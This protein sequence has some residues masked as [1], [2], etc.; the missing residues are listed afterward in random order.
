MKI[1]RWQLDESLHE[2]DTNDHHPI[3]QALLPYGYT[4][5]GEGPGK[6]DLRHGTSKIRV[7]VIRRDPELILRMFALGPVEALVHAKNILIGTPGFVI[8]QMPS[9]HVNVKYSK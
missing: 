8:Q 3:A 2:E 4:V 5:E 7:E 9:G 1:R 6:M